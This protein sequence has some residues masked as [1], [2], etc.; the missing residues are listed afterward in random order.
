[1]SLHPYMTSQL[2]KALHQ[3]MLAQAERRRPARQLGVL[4]RALRR[5]HRA[6]RRLRLAA[7]RVLELNADLEQ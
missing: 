5:A 1:V 4:G 3:E 7:R 2:A 6:E